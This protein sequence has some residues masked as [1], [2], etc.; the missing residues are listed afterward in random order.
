M[1][2]ARPDGTLVKVAATGDYLPGGGVLSSVSIGSKLAAGDA[3]KFALGASIARGSSR[4]AIFV[5][6]IPPGT[7]GTTTELGPLA[8]PAVAQ[9]SLALSA[10]VTSAAAGTPTGMVT[11]FA[12]GISLGA[13]TL[14][15]GG[16]ATT[17]TSSLAA[18]PNSLIAQYGG[19]SNFAPGDSTP[20]LIVVAGFATPP[21]NLTVA[22]GQNLVVPLTVFAPAGSAMNFTLSCS[23][24]AANTACIF[25]MNP[26]APVSSGTT[27]HLTLTTKSSSK[28]TP[29]S[30]RKVF[31]APTALGVAAFFAALLAAA[32]LMWRQ[33]PRLRFVCC[34]CVATFALAAILGGCGVTGYTLRTPPASGTPT[35]TA[36][37]T[38]TGISG[39]TT[40]STVLNVTVR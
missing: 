36:S 38:V 18:G 11:F 25:D 32:T 26:V 10:T 34:A 21:S 30:S 8:N 6:A 12:E 27:I 4:R 17:N 39:S 28:L 13:G 22:A 31:P 9:K 1:F 29:P 3:G 24:L 33:A 40:V 20:L 5:T 16:Q 14:S 19:D 7:S 37:F 35:G 2:V 23:G 15:A